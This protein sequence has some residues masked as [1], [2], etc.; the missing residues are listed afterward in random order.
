MKRIISVGVIVIAIMIADFEIMYYGSSTFSNRRYHNVYLVEE[1]DTNIHVLQRYYIDDQSL[2]IYKEPEDWYADTE[3]ELYYIGNLEKYYSSRKPEEKT[4]IQTEENTKENPRVIKEET[5]DTEYEGKNSSGCFSTYQRREFDE[6]GDQYSLTET[7][8]GE[9]AVTLY[10]KENNVVHT[11]VLPMLPWVSEVSDKIL[12]IGMSGGDISSL[13]FYFDKERAKVSPYYTE[14]FYLRDNYI[15]YME[16]EST[17]VL[18]DIFEDNELHMEISRDFSDSRQIGGMHHSI[19]DITMITLNGRNVVV[20]EYYE[21]EE[22]EL[23]SD[24][25]PLDEE[26]IVFNEL[27]EIERNYEFLKYD[28]CSPVLYD[29][30]KINPIVKKHIEYEVCNNEEIS[31]KYGKELE[32]SVDYHTFDFNDD[33]LDDYLLCVDRELYDGREEHWIH[34]YITKQERGWIAGREM[35]DE[36]V[37]QVLELNLPLYN[38]VEEIEHKQIMVLD[39][40]ISGYYTIVLPES[41][42]ILRYDDQYDRYEFCDQ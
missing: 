1:S 6:Y 5:V 41:N 18:T 13:I 27:D 2:K 35:V 14:S 31:Q 10:D 26:E 38:Q 4:T 19:K 22:R 9:F 36:M 3:I 25:I 33:G 42:L 21:G 40:Q 7:E 16:D 20:L 30:E 34:I 15:A 37:K 32:V 17:L 11:E 24:I 23:I 12:Q 8:D 28:I 29:F 39:E